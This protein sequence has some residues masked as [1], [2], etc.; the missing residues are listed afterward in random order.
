MRMK[1]RQVSNIKFYIIFMFDLFFKYISDIYNIL[2]TIYI[3][4]YFDIL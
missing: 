4:W 3:F 2:Y 1:K